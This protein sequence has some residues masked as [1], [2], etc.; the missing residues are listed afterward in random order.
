MRHL[1]RGTHHRTPHASQTHQASLR[2]MRGFDRFRVTVDADFA[3]RSIGIFRISRLIGTFRI[4]RWMGMF[5][6][7]ADRDM[8]HR[9]RFS[10]PAQGRVGLTRCGSD[11][12]CQDHIIAGTS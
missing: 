11:S 12:L 8:S 10:P 2:R 3:K 1:E 4:A 6:I 5:R 7:E 9:G